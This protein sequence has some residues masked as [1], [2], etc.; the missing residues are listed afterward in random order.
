ME[1]TRKERALTESMSRQCRL[2]LE[3][4]ADNED[5][6]VFSASIRLVDDLEV[7]DGDD[8]SNGVL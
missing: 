3:R 5:G 4:V 6:V 7:G 1:R 8:I 2:S